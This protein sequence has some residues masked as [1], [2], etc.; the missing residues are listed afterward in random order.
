M[1]EIEQRQAMR[2][3]RIRLYETKIFELQMDLLA[4][5]ATGDKEGESTVQQALDQLTSALEAV[6][7][8]NLEAQ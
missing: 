6:S 3:R 8:M 2:T 4:C 1:L 5:Q 7:N